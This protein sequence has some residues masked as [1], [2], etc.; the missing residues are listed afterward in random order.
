M[1]VIFTIFYVLIAILSF[2]YTI[3]VPVLW[4]AAVYQRKYRTSVDNI[5]WTHDSSSDN[6]SCSLEVTNIASPPLTMKEV[7][8]KPSISSYDYKKVK[9]IGEGGLPVELSML[10]KKKLEVVFP[11]NLSSYEEKNYRDKARSKPWT[12]ILK[13][14]RLPLRYKISSPLL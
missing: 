5:A 1:S 8:V 12:I 13:T 9:Y 7:Y 3:C 14:N 6:I 11:I 2:A 10:D 4:V